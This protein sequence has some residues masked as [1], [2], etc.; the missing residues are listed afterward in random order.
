MFESQIGG[1][2]NGGNVKYLKNGQGM[3]IITR[4]KFHA[5]LIDEPN[6][7][8][9]YLERYCGNLSIKIMKRQPG[10][11]TKN[12]PLVKGNVDFKI[13]E[14][15]KKSVQIKNAQKVTQIAFDS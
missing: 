12:V 9:L 14:G 3:Y 4:N 8:E 11:V 1:P 10:E 7:Q 15:P 13:L 5:K 2:A 6:D